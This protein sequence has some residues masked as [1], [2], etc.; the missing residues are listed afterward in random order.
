[1]GFLVMAKKKILIIEDSKKLLANI[2]IFLEGMDF[3]VNTALDGEAGLKQVKQW[4]PDLIICDINI[5]VKDG[6]QVLDEISKDNKAKTIPFI[7][8]TAK[9]EK[10][11][12]RKGMQL[13]AD[14][15]IF[16]PFDLDDLLKSINHRLEKQSQRKTKS[17]HNELAQ[18]GPYE[19][20]D[21]MLLSFGKRMEFCPV[22]DLKFIKTEH[23]Y[24]LLK[25]FGGKNTLIRKSLDEWESLLP[26]KYFIRVHQSTIVNIEFVTKIERINKSAYIVRLKDEEE[27]FIVSRRFGQKIKTFLP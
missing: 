2:K 21:K 12:L 18:E 26:S 11:E 27:P 23:P 3:V 10:E 24:A 5:P 14:D 15:Y 9:V 25:F 16:K 6:Y 4:Q 7:F 20:E 22:K 8:L 1:M 19:I 17:S 13:G